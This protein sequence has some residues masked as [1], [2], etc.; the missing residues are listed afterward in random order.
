M[1]SVFLRV[2]DYLLKL[3]FARFTT[4]ARAILH[5]SQPVPKPSAGRKLFSA[6][7]PPFTKGAI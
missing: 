5:V 1:I 7:I 6:T 4:A 2:R 3:E